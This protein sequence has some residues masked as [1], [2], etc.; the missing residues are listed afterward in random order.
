[1][2]A[3]RDIASGRR[4]RA[5]TIV[6][7]VLQLGACTADLMSEQATLGA[8]FCLAAPGNGLI[9]ALGFALWLLLSLSW[10]VG[11]AGL[12]LAPL[13]PIYWAL[14]AAIPIAWAVQALL[15]HRRLL[16]CDAP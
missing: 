4:A 13:R 2:A 11:L 3:W 10:L 6:L 14:V 12:R 1:V 15:L 7:L 8:L 16:F 9:E 5:A